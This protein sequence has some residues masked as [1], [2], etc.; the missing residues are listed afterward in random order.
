MKL[1]ISCLAFFLI[2]S[3]IFFSTEKCFAQKTRYI[4][5]E[6]KLDSTEVNKMSV[7][8]KTEREIQK[9]W[10]KLKKGMTFDEVLK[11]LGNPDSSACTVG[12]T[13]YFWTYK[14]GELIFNGVSKTLSKWDK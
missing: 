11:L 7:P 8:I 4:S 3:I 9:N 10:S 2:P 14:R 12:F 1:I 6:R 13:Q 5:V